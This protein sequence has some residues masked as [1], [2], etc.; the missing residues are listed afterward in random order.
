MVITE[1][2][3]ERLPSDKRRRFL[4]E[5]YK[6]FSL[7]SYE[8]ASITHLVKNLGIAK[9]SVY[10][11]FKDK[12]SL[13]LYLI[14]DAFNQVEQLLD[15][16]CPVLTNFGFRDWYE[17][18][19]MVYLKILLSFPIYGILFDKNQHETSTKIK[20]H[21]LHL[22][23]EKSMLQR[24]IQSLPEL[25][26]YEVTQLKSGPLFLFSL[27]VEQSGQDIEVY[28]ESGATLE[29]PTETI[30]ELCDQFVHPLPIFDT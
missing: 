11:Y 12:Q 1:K 24:T 17:N 10:Q 2:T 20:G 26:L 8:S 16:T 22:L 27:L 30:L 15:K 18:Y 6:E 14:D 9:G 29:L 21:Y 23:G 13:Y 19:L 28:L 5:A 3:F 7:H 4:S 25:S